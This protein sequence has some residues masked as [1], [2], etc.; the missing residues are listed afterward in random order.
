MFFEHE[1]ASD[2]LF[3]DPGYT[4]RVPRPELHFLV[5]TNDRGDGAE[6]PCCARAESLETYRRLKDAVRAAGRRESVLATRT[7]CLRR[8]S[9][10]PTVVVW[11]ANRWYAGVSAGDVDELLESELAGRELER[12]RMP[13]GPWE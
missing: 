3:R 6:R 9:H 13:E 10:G 11:P 7:G 1:Q 2:A 12:L 8:C 5:C 4:P